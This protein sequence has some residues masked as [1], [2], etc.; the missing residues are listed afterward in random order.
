MDIALVFQGFEIAKALAAYLRIVETI[1]GKIDRLSQ[2]EFDAGLRALNQAK[3]SDLETKSL[4]RES[5]ARFNKAIS[6][7]QWERLALA[8]LGLAICHFHLGDKKNSIE[9][10]TFL[11]DLNF[12]KAD[13]LDVV[14]ALPKFFLYVPHFMV[15]KLINEYRKK[16]RE[17]K[18]E[19]ILLLQQKIREYLDQNTD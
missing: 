8:H 2:S 1:D 15:L 3:N 16:I 18:L 7:E 9:A 6:I 12:K 4:L 17:K 14:D 19:K 11:R 10:L 5:R 13:F